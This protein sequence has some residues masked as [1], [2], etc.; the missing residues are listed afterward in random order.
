MSNHNNTSQNNYTAA[1]F[2]HAT[3]IEESIE[4]ET[5]EPSLYDYVCGIEET[6]LDCETA[7]V[8]DAVLSYLLMAY[9]TDRET[10]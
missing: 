10:M 1:Y 2:Y 6:P 9:T 7:D 3:H 8:L 5:P 4:D